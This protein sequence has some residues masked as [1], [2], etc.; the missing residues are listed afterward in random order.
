[1]EL[2]GLLSTPIN[3]GEVPV[4]N[5]LFADDAMIICEANLI[6]VGHPSFFSGIAL[7]TPALK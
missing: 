3:Q 4:T 7:H 2:N 5:L 6:H 1:M